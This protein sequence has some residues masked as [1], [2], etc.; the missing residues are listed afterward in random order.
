MTDLHSAYGLIHDF[1][2]QSMQPVQSQLHQIDPMHSQLQ[3]YPLSQQQSNSQPQKSVMIKQSQSQSHQ[4]HQDQQKSVVIKPTTAEQK[5]QQS[6]ASYIDQLASKKRD[7][8]KLILM[9]LV[10]LLALGTH[11]L[12]AFAIKNYVIDQKLSYRQEIGARL[13]YPILVLVILWNLKT[14]SSSNN[15]A[16]ARE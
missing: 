7:V 16:A 13:L 14:V 8:A 12:L 15:R 1:Q 2:M 11:D 5:S 3:V 4:V 9:A 6:N 10:I